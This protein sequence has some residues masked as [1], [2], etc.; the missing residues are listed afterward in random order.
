MADA[1]DMMWPVRISLLV[2]ASSLWAQPITLHFDPATTKVE[3][4]LGSTLHTVHG[5]F[6]LKR[7]ELTFDTATGK[8]SGALVVDATT[9]QSGSSGRDHK[10][11]ESILESGRYPEIVFRPDSVEGKV[12]PAGHSDV[13]L[14]GTL[15]IHGADHEISVPVS[16]DAGGGEYKG[17]AKFE[18]PYIKWGM[19]N[20]STF[21]LRVND[22]VIITVETAAR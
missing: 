13:Q 12:E 5:T 16:V 6:R 4:S 20:P 11:H 21:I 19:K 7:G 17:I 8:A 1:L 9:G 22:K 18:V 3:Y 15:T 2:A 14:R 10:M